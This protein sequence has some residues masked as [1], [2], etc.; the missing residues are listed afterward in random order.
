VRSLVGSI[1][2]RAPVPYVSKRLSFPMLHRNDAESQMRA[3]GAVGTLFAT[4]HRTSADTAKV[5]WRLWRKA[6][7]GKKE[8]RTEVT[9]HAALDLWNRPNPFYTRQEFVETFQQHIDLTGEGWWVVGRNPRSPLPLELWPVRPDRMAPVPSA[10]DFIAGYVYTGPDGEKIP[11]ELADVMQLKMPNPLDPYRGLGPVQAILTDIDSEKYSAEWNRNF[12]VNGAEPGGIIELPEHLGDDEF[13]EMTTR[14][15]EQHQGVANAHRVAVIER[16]GKWVDR[17]YSM[18]DMQFTELRRA[19]RETIREAFGMSKTM[20][21]AAESE[22]NRATAEAAEYVYAKY[23]ITERLDRIKGVLNTELLALYGPGAGD[24]EFDYE[25]PVPENAEADNAGRD[26][27]VAAA[28]ALIG[29]GADPAETMQ[30]FEL[31]DIPFAAPT[32]APAPTGPLPPTPA[33]IEA[34]AIDRALAAVG[35]NRA[36]WRQ[37]RPA[38][39]RRTSN[40]ADDDVPPDLD[41]DDLP[42]ITHLQES[43]EAELADLLDEWGP[44][45]DDQKADLVD[46]IREIAESGELSDLTDVVIDSGPGADVLLDAMVRI[47]AE[48][49]EQ[50]IEE[51][52][53][54]GVTVEPQDV[55]EALLSDVATVVAAVRAGVLTGGALVAALRA[56]GPEATADDVADAV[57]DHL[58]SLSPDGPRPLLGGA[59]TGAQNAGR[60]ETLRAAP[61]GALYANERNDRNTCAPCREVNGRWLGNVSDMDRVLASYPGGAYGGYIL[62]LGRERCRGT[63]TGVWRPAQVGERA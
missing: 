51:A 56:N 20:L 22:T 32:P 49:A 9:R 30:A 23:Q 63:I 61:E 11:L 44:V 43:W 53:E 36:S 41:P 25:D 4:V 28:V 15:R 19:S 2:D 40:A 33:A 58:E 3:Y 10:T 38:R 50:V 52:A 39:R 55:A 18:R 6:A 42:D 60:I 14:W 48:A 12:F 8:D 47:A 35:H 16:G 31:P 29:Q 7:S 45:E 13:D 26:S 27:K 46:A 1:L 57:A 17:K 24:L 5:E 34:R 54:Q 37:P 59:L 62:C 21:G